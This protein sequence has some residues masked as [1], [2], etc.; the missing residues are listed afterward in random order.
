[1]AEY[2]K[3]ILLWFIFRFKKYIVDSKEELF[4]LGFPKFT[5]ED[6]HDMVNY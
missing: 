2:A 3:L 1:M 4:S 5:T 6:F